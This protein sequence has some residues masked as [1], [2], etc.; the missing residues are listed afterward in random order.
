MMVQGWIG[1][2][3]RLS[4]VIKEK[5]GYTLIAIA[6]KQALKAENSKRVLSGRSKTTECVIFQHG[7]SLNVSNKK[8]WL[9]M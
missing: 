8:L 1:P 5:K 7:I 9:L 4:D 6:T 3:L 2:T